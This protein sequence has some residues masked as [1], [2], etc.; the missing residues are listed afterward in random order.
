MTILTVNALQKTGLNDLYDNS[1]TSLVKNPNHNNFLYHELILFE[2][3][4]L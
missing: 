4:S 3:S 2:K 1:N